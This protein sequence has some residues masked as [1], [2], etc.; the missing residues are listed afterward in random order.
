MAKTYCKYYKMIITI[1]HITYSDIVQLT[2]M[3]KGVPVPNQRAIT[4]VVHLSGHLQAEFK[5]KL[6]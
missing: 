1:Q 4:L 3:S 6:G 2:I 5:E